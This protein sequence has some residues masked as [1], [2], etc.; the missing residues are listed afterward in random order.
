[1]PTVRTA[2]DA[3]LD[4]QQTAGAGPLVPIVLD[5]FV[6]ERRGRTS[7]GLLRLDVW[8]EDRVGFLGS[9]LGSL[10]GLS[11]FPSEMAIETTAGIV[12]DSFTLGSI[13]GQPPSATAEKA[14]LT[15]LEALRKE[16]GRTAEVAPARLA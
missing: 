11:L 14:L 1:M 4:L 8:G 6:L 7:T 12:A 10:S 3:F 5:R 16:N 2:E 9:L 15:L 13:G